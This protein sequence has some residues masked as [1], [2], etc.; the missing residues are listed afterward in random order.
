M[1]ALSLAQLRSAPPCLLVTMLLVAVARGAGVGDDVADKVQA[2]YDATKDFTADVHQELVMASAGK[3]MHA[4]GTVAFKKPGKMRWTLTDGVAQVIVADGKTLWFYQPDEQQVLKAPFQS[5]VPLDARRS[6]FS[7]ASAGSPTTSRS[8]STATR[9]AACVLPLQPRKGEA[10][11]RRA[12]ALTVDAHDATTSSA[13]RSTT[14]SATSPGCASPIC[15][16]TS[17]STTTQF[18][19]D[20]PPGVDVIEAPIGN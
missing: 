10:R 20:V 17:A 11:A 16:A 19:F 13:P 9:T 4:N 15:A 14:R 6:R 1:P 8:R 2:R 12:C 7:P 5:G 3:T 18:Q